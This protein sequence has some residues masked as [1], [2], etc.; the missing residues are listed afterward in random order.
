MS[1]KKISRPIGCHVSAAGGIHNALITAK[2]HGMSAIQVHPTPPQKWNFKP[3]AEG[4][5][6]EYLSLL[7]N[8]GVDAIFFHG[9]YLINLANPDPQKVH[10]AVESLANDLDY[11]GRCKAT[12][13]IFHVG[14]LKDEPVREEGFKRATAAINKILDKSKKSGATLLLEVSAGAGSVIGSRMEDLA[15]IFEGIEDKSRAGFALDTQHL[16]ASGYNIK[17]NLDSFVSNLESTL[18]GARVKAIHLNDSKSDCASKIDRHENLGLGKI[19][20]D[21]LRAFLSTPSLAHAPVVLETPGLKDP[22]GIAGE[23]ESL[24]K[25]LA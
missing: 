14:S 24:K 25:L 21:A 20:A 19:G 4:I 3:M 13:V 9:I 18:T 16:W 12:G 5:E 6:N 7:P 23:F 10:F 8:S 17:D 11:A 22:E 1:T 2:I 15:E